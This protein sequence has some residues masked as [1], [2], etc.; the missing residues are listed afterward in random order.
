[1]MSSAAQTVT[2]YLASLP[3]GRR[4][5][6]ARLRQLILKRLP[7][8]FEEC[9]EYGMISY[10]VPL[11]RYPETYNRKPLALASLASQKQHM[12]LYLMS[13][14][15]EPDTE[16]WLAEQFQQAGKRLDMG[17][18][19]IR[20]KALA[21]LPLDVIGDA[22]ARVSV[23]E[24]I[25][26]YERARG[27]TSGARTVSAARAPGSG[28]SRKKAV[29]GRKAVK[30]KAAGKKAVKATTT[31]KKTSGKRARAGSGK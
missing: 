26:V 22:I 2:S 9:M 20:F 12:A 11:S 30:K 29:A 5:P 14:Y 1:M 16:R 27:L 23:D 13:V 7:A 8:G 18:S 21:D 24:Y 6:I 15:G 28:L 19:C 31:K 17:K 3:E 10:V 25:A 4:E